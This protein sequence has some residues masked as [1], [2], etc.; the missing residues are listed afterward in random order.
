MIT[1]IGLQ[2]I[3][4]REYNNYA[5]KLE[6]IMKKRETDLKNT[7]TL[8]QQKKQLLDMYAMEELNQFSILIEQSNQYNFD[9]TIKYN[10]FT[11]E[12]GSNG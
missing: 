10:V 12:N 4:T 3:I 6:I 5:V 8:E 1:L 11:K 2:K 7:N 9:E